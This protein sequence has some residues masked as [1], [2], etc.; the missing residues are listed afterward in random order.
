MV[1]GTAGG[2]SNVVSG[3]GEYG[4]LI[5]SFGA[6]NKGEGVTQSSVANVCRDVFAA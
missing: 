6:T 4:F 3:N 1:G 2:T 5:Q